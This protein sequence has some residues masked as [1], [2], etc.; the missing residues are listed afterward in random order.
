MKTLQSPLMWSMLIL[1]VAFYPM[2]IS[3]YVFLPLFIGMMGY[4][5]IVGIEKNR[6]SYLLISSV[7]LINLEANLSLPFFLTLIATLLVYLFFYRNLAFFKRCT[8]C[9]P[10]ITVFLID[11]C[12]LAIILGYDFIF[13]TQS[14]VLDKI[15]LYSL[16]VDVLVV[17]IFA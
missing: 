6:W 11:L 8:I 15:L 14:I 1:F 9:A 12:Y 10:V 3:I 16:I 5:M 13:Q 7:Y 17:V 2:L 4:M